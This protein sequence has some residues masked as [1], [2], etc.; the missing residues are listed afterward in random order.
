MEGVRSQK[1]R[2]LVPSAHYERMYGVDPEPHVYELMPQC[3]DHL[4]WPGGAWKDS[5]ELA[6]KL[7]LPIDREN[8]C[9]QPFGSASSCSSRGRRMG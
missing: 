4:H 1:N 5:R 3:A 7:S 6:G 9:S 2:W 8:P